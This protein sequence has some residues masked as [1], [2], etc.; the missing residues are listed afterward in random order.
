MTHNA[1]V[2]KDILEMLMFSLYP[3]AET[4]YREYLQN[5]CDSINEAVET[6]LLAKQEDG[7]VTINIDTYHQKVTISDNGT[8]IVAKEAESRLKDIAAGYKKHKESAAG[9]YGIGRLVGAGYCKQLSFKT[10]AFGENVASEMVFDVEKIREILNDD[11][12]NLSASEVIDAVTTLTSM[13]ESE[14]EHYFVV[15]LTDIL[16]EYP[17]LVNEDLI[18]KYLVQVAP[19]P[20]LPEFKNNLIKPNITDEKDV[21]L[22]YYKRLNSIQ[23]SVNNIVNIRK[24]Y[25]LTIDGTGDEIAK[26]RFF[27]LTDPQYGDLAWGWYAITPFEK[28][29][30]DIDPYNGN[31][32]VLTRGIR[33]RVHNIQIGNE[34]FFDGT[35]YFRQARSNKYFNGEIHVV[36]SKIK[37]T[38]D[39]SDLAPSK[40]ALKLKELISDFFNS[41]LQKVYQTANKVKKEFERIVEA[42]T[43]RV[44]TEKL[45]IS[46]DF[47]EKSKATQL[48]E[49][50]KKRTEAESEFDKY[51][52]KKDNV[53]EG[54]KA[55]LDVYQQKFDKFK[56]DV[57]EGKIEL[58]KGKDKPKGREAKP[59][60]DED[61][62]T[63]VPKYGEEKIDMLKR[64]FQIIDTRY[65]SSKYYEQVIKG[66][67]SSVVNDLK[68]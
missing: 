22:S 38:T 15:T 6:N 2:G 58:D 50:I 5:A 20:Y 41:E 19:I 32:R 23:V 27:T 3:E 36:N 57:S 13:P 26:L 51:Q 17:E 46:T 30:P 61:I 48:S 53:S 65:K 39:R 66:V 35:S 34:N 31:T 47:P 67:K 18:Y 33:L 55:M 11:E 42:E 37:P 68:K 7:H 25:G 12:C 4:I 59:S 45:D 64:V 29:I 10:S 28:A 63:L 60:I 14:S 44:E 24:P 52:N 16:P 43:I 21:F 54:M 9:F 56:K 1:I 40:E 8:G 49:S 62:A